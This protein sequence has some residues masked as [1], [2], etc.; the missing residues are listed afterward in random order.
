M[1]LPRLPGPCVEVPV[2]KNKVTNHDGTKSWDVETHVATELDLDGH[3]SPVVLV[4]PTDSDLHPDDM[5]WRL[6]VM[7][8]EC[9][10]ELGEVGGLDEPTLE[11][12]SSHELRN[13]STLSSISPS[14]RSGGQRGNL[15]LT[16][17]TFD[18]QRY[19]ASKPKRQ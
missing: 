13:I 10:H 19:R 4:P 16:S 14:Q 18:G 6:Y 2:V 1:T 5:L 8:G 15:V 7:R 17:Y 11:E 3:G 12:G 9:G